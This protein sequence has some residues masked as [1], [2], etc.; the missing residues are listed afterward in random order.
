MRALGQGQNA[1]FLHLQFLSPEIVMNCIA[2][3]ELIE[4]KPLAET[5]LHGSGAILLDGLFDAE[6]KVMGRARRAAVK[7]SLILNFQTAEIIFK[8]AQLLIDDHETSLPSPVRFAP[9]R[10]STTT[11]ITDK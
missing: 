2:L 7:V 6:N 8:L 5:H 1:L 9:S 4:A 10:F 3:R 11:I